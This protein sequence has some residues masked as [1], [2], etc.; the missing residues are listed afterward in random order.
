MQDHTPLLKS[1]NQLTRLTRLHLVLPILKRQQDP[2]GDPPPVFRLVLPE[3]AWL[4]VDVGVVKLDAQGCPKLQSC[5]RP[6]GPAAA[7]T[8]LRTAL[9]DGD[10]QLPW[11]VDEEIEEED[12]RE[13]VHQLFQGNPGPYEA[14]QEDSILL[15]MSEAPS[16]MYGRE[17]RGYWKLRIRVKIA[18]S[19]LCS[20][21]LPM[22]ICLILRHLVLL[23]P[24]VGV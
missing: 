14:S 24:L 19:F 7:V 21:C 15:P 20:S 3:L 16:W 6:Q 10:V 18:P 5:L 17:Y 11:E 4:F 9:E 13:F 22:V 12:V 1:I 8:Q 23:V 2:P